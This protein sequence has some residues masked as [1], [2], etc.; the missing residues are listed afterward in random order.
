MAYNGGVGR[1]YHGMSKSP[2]Y[3]AWKDMRDRVFN[4]NNKHFKDYGGRGIEIDSS[5]L[6]SFIQFYSDVGDRPDKRYSLDRI[7]NDGDYT[8]ENVRWATSAE[9]AR[10]RRSQENTSTGQV[11]IWKVGSK[12]RASI[13]MHRKSIYVGL[14]NTLDEAVLARMDAVNELK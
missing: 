14:Y 12:Y 1:E 8:P 3:Q 11:G 5:W 4:V 10:N 13:N 7:D 2:E 9:Q 6:Y